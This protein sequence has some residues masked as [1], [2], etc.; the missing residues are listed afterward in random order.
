MGSLLYAV[1]VPAYGGDTMFANQYL[2]YDA[3]SPG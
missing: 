1:E 2:A 3:L